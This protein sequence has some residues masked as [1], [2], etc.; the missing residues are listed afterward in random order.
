VQ[1]SLSCLR[2]KSRPCLEYVYNI[3]D[4]R[5]GLVTPA[6]I[7]G[8]VRSA[9]RAAAV[10]FGGRDGRMLAARVEPKKWT[11][12]NR[13]TPSIEVVDLCCA[14]TR[15]HVQHGVA[16]FSMVLTKQLFSFSHLPL[17]MRI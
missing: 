6:A 2:A 17:R 4:F 9:L 10:R 8:V 13:K 16:M 1:A 12:Q 7:A 14:Q 3:V 11:Q 15:R 5:K